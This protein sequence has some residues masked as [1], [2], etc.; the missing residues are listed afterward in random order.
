MILLKFPTHTLQ[1]DLGCDFA[2]FGV[3]QSSSSSVIEGDGHMR[4]DRGLETS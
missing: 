4:I 1:P 3:S 2:L